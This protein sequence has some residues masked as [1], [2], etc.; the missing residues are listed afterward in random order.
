MHLV[1]EVVPQQLQQISVT[2][3]RPLLITG[4]PGH[5]KIINEGSKICYNNYVYGKGF[6]LQ[7]VN[8]SSEYLPL[9]ILHHTVALDVLMV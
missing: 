7:E 9:A 6:I 3:L 1:E 8:Q 5:I 4:K 2:S